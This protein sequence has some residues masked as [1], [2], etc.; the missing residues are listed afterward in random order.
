MF[1]IE[2]RRIYD[3]WVRRLV[4]AIVAPLLGAGCSTENPLYETGESAASNPSSTSETIGVGPEEGTQPDT[5][6]QTSGTTTITLTSTGDETTQGQTTG[7]TS[8]G[9]GE[10]SS[11]ESSSD[12]VQA[13]QPIYMEE[14]PLRDNFLVNGGNGC[15]GMPC[16]DTCYGTTSIGFVSGYEDGMRDSYMLLTFDLSGFQEFGVTDEATLFLR[17]YSEQLI[18]FELD[19][20]VVDPGPWLEGIGDEGP[21]VKNSSSWNYSMFPTTWAEGATTDFSAILDAGGPWLGPQSIDT[22]NVPIDLISYTIPGDVVANSLDLDQ[23]LSLVVTVTSGP[24][25]LM[26]HALDSNFL[27]P[28]LGFHAC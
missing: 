11:T 23:H 28:Y 12:D 14:N 4:L 6:N 15:N 21:V 18:T 5:S 7:D 19:A 2:D 13:C 8:R 20:R 17:V 27:T 22:M 26:L 1:A 3:H 25:E 24:P 9:S 16:A 10:T